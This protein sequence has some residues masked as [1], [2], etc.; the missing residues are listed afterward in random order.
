MREHPYCPSCICGRRAP[1]Q[2]SAAIPPDDWSRLP[3]GS[4]AKGPGTIAWA[5]HACAWGGYAL[6]RGG[7]QSAERIAERGGFSYPELMV[8]LGHEPETWAPTR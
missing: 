6:D 1:V 3:Q 4:P 8:Y 2:A 7:G 5:E